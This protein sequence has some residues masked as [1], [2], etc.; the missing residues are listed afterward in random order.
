MAE[1]HIVRKRKPL[2][3][4]FFALVG[5]GLGHLYSGNIGMAIGLAAAAVTFANVF[6]LLVIH[7]KTE[8][9]N[10]LYALGVGLLGHLLY[11]LHAW[12]TARRQPKDYL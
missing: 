12:D 1:K 3:A 9:S 4:F 2:L 5:P 11:T 6:F 8:T 7:T 10:L